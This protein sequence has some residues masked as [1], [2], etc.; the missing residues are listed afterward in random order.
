MSAQSALQG[1]IT[2]FMKLSTTNASDPLDRL[3]LNG[4][5][6]GILPL[7]PGCRKIVGPA[8]TMKLVPLG[9][10]SDSPVNGSLEAAKSGRPGDVLVI[11][12]GGNMAVNSY[13]GIVGF[14]THH[15]GLAGCVIDGVARDLD[16]YKEL[17]LPVY[18]RGVVQQSI[19]NRCAFGGHSIEVQLGGVRVTPGDL[20]MADENGVVVI[21][22]ERAGEVLKIAQ[23]VHTIETRIVEAIRA[24]EDPIQAHEKVRYDSMTSPSS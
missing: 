10:S 23:E 11:D 18:A 5:P 13:G 24:G 9:D 17:D 12:H 6:H 19:R 20:V 15:R 7:W 21:P 1:L 16:E 14:T 4:A 3:A 22:R 8:V 2:E